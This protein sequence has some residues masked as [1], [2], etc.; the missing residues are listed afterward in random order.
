MKE[1]IQQA[2]L[3]FKDG[4]LLTN[5]TSLLNVLGYN[6]ELVPGDDDNNSPSF[7]LEEH[8]EN[9]KVNKTTAFFDK[10]KTAEIIFQ[11]TEEELKGQKGL[12]SVNELDRKQYQSYI[13]IA[14]E[15]EDQH[16]TRTNLSDITRQINRLFIMPAMIFFKY[17]NK[18][19]V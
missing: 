3:N 4:S 7:F 15:L 11:I 5:T 8:E 12:F 10:W 17:G 9:Y 2:I 13:F 14:I 1:K 16:Y 6:S 18:L 19:L